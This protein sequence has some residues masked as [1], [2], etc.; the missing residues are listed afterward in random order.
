MEALHSFH[1]KLDIIHNRQRVPQLYANQ[2]P[3]LKNFL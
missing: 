2:D 3:I 1:N